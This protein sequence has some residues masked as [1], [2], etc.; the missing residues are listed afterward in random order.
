MDVKV[1]VSNVL[2]GDHPALN[3]AGIWLREHLNVPSN[4]TIFEEFEEYFNC[5]IDV[6]DRRDYFMQPN[7][8]VF[9]NSKDLIAFLLKWS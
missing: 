1:D 9:G 2:P 7:Q 4:Q 8:V 3:E 6:D 5:R